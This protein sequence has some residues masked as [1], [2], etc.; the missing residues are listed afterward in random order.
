MRTHIKLSI[1]CI[2]SVLVLGG[3]ATS[4]PA[5]EGQLNPALGHAVD[6]NKAAHA[7]APSAAQKANTFIPADPMRAQQARQNYRNNT[8]A[9][10][11]RDEQ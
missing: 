3:C 10:P 9:K 1:G 11:N 8:I 6:A 4:K 7:V 2:V 5:L